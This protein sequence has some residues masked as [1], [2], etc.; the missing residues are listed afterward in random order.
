MFNI[1]SYLSNINSYL[2]IINSYLFS[3]LIALETKKKKNM[4]LYHMTDMV[5]SNLFHESYHRIHDLP[6]G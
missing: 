5:Y 3:T 1:N 6:L 2:F 4:N